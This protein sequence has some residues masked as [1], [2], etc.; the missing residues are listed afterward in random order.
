MPTYVIFTRESTTDQSS[1]DKYMENVRPTLDGHS[2]KVLSAYGSQQALEGQEPEG[3][4]LLEFPSK[5]DALAWYHSP[6]YA[7]VVKYRF[8]GARYRVVMADSN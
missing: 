6:D 2:V 7:D 8:Q 5:S 1:L 4:V 3:V